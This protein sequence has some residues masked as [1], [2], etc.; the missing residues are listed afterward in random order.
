MSYC[1]SC[2]VELDKSAEKCALCDTVVIN[3]NIRETDEP[4][5]PPYPERIVI[6]KGVRRRYVAFLVSIVFLIP[7]LVSVLI[8]VLF[9]Q[10]GMWSVYVVAT[11]ALVWFLF[12]FPLLLKRSRPYLLLIVDTIASLLYIYVF[13]EMHRQNAWF[14]QVALPLVLMFFFICLFSLKWLSKDRDWVHIAIVV[15][16]EIAIFSILTDFIINRFYQ[17]GHV[18]MVSIVIAASCL[19]LIAFFLFVSKNKRF[20]AWLSR[21]FFV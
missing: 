10:S 4:P 12:V 1:V 20:R 15:L 8:N 2:G 3:P 21:K 6:P 17:T 11:S 7:N 18:I 5:E 9:P 13:Y 16:A 14:F 19:A